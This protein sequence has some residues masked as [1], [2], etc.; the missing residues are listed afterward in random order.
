[1]KRGTSPPPWFERGVVLTRGC[2]VVQIYRDRGKTTYDELMNT[3]PPGF[4]SRYNGR[5]T[6]D[7]ADARPR[8]ADRTHHGARL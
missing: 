7:D 8:D 5:R 3:D 4:V 2:T 6:G 1:M